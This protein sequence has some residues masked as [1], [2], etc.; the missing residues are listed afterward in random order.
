MHYKKYL[1]NVYTPMN[2]SNHPFIVKANGYG[3]KIC[4]MERKYL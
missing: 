3:V 2:S 4:Q 1:N